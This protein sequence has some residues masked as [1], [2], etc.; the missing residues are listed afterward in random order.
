[1][2]IKIQFKSEAQVSLPNFDDVSIFDILIVL[3]KLIEMIAAIP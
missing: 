2:S 1:M 3:S